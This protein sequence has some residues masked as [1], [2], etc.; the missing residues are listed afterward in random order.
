MILVNAHVTLRRWLLSNLGNSLNA[1]WA[2]LDIDYAGPYFGHM[3]LVIVDAHL[4]VDGDQCVQV[5]YVYV[6]HRTSQGTVHNTQ[7]P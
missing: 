1:P 4:R 6:Y 3:F 5:S 7:A 2:R